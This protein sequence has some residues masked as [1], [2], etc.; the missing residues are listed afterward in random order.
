MYLG[1]GL[2]RLTREHFIEKTQPKNGFDS[3]FM[4]TFAIRVVVYAIAILFAL[5]ESTLL[6]LSISVL[7]GIMWRPWIIRHGIGCLHAIVR[8]ALIVAVRHSFP[9]RRDVAVSAVI[10][11]AYAVA[12]AVFELRWRRTQHTVVVAA[13]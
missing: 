10:I 11:A 7:A 2:S 12:I 8:M 9:E 6:P 5:V 13:V 3:F 1:I 4:R